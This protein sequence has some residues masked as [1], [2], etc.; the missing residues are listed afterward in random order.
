MLM[1][2][3]VV[4]LH[5]SLGQLFDISDLDVLDANDLIDVEV[6]LLKYEGDTATKVFE[7]HRQLLRGICEGRRARLR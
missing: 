2:I 3:R 7:R 6:D 5:R 4:G 1:E